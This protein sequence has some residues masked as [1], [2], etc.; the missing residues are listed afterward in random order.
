MHFPQLSD[1]NL[2]KLIPLP[3][4]GQVN[5]RNTLLFTQVLDNRRRRR[6]QI[7]FPAGDIHMARL[8]KAHKGYLLYKALTGD[9]R[10]YRGDLA[11]LTYREQHGLLPLAERAPPDGEQV[12]IGEGGF[13]AAA[14]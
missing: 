13:T 8:G 3:Q 2:E 5:N 6:I 1:Q 14:V 10:E 12:G 11:I 7:P 4:P 9:E